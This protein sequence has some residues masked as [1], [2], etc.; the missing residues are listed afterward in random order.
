MNKIKGIIF[1]MDN[2][3]LRSRID[4]ASMK[5]DTFQ[6]L[7]SHGILQPNVILNNHTTAT[8]IEKAINTNLMTEQLIQK[9]WEIPTRYE[10]EGMLD[11]D[12]EPGVIEL[13]EQ[14]RSEYCM[15]IVTNNAI[16]AA[17]TALTNNKIMHYFDSVVGRG[18]MGSLKPSPDGFHYILRKYD[19]I[20]A[21]EWISVGDSWIDGKA[22]REAN[23]N[24]IS[25]QGDIEKMNRMGVFPFAEIMDIREL[26]RFL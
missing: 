16:E 8:I 25:Y 23:I 18:L 24:F 19:H 1:D 2:T 26:V 21:E 14:L 11:A 9:M 15:V 5:N 6:F 3:I 13:L 12:L 10:A 22:S 17:E 20:P 4:F 7:V